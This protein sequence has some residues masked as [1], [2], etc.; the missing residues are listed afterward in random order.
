MLCETTHL[1]KIVHGFVDFLNTPLLHKP[2]TNSFTRY[3]HPLTCTP[4][5]SDSHNSHYFSFLFLTCCMYSN[6][7][8]GIVYLTNIEYIVCLRKVLFT[9]TY[10]YNLSTILAFG[11][12]CIKFHRKR[13]EKTSSIS[14]T[15]Q[16]I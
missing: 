4:I 7:E 8:I 3:T 13:L 1:Y 15:V 11:I 14:D 2:C 9:I 6:L 5:T 10:L 12:L 16:G